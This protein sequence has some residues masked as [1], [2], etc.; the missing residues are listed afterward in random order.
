MMKTDT[1]QGFVF[2]R[3]RYAEEIIQPDEKSTVVQKNNSA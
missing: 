1:M 2:E 3:G